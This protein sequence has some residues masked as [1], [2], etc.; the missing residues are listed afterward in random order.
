MTRHFPAG[1]V[2]LVAILFA[3]PAQ[4]ATAWQAKPDANSISWSVDMG[5]GN[6]LRGHCGVFD[7]DIVFDPADL[8]HSHV[9]VTVDMRSCRTGAEDKDELLP[10][11]EWFSEGAF[12]KAEF[13]AAKFRSLGATRYVADG[14]LKLKGVERKLPLEFNLELNGAQAH[15]KGSALLQRM[16]FG[17]GNNTSA[18]YVGL[19]VKVNIDL[20][21][22]KK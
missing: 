18:D 19:V 11:S 20:K 21:A 13:A 12:P 1:A 15:A 5:G 8:A 2:A 17:I 10:N 9:K 16:D 6:L 3:L 14:A 4:A 7:S 22:S